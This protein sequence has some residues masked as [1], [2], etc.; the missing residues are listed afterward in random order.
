MKIALTTT[1]ALLAGPALAQTDPGEGIGGIG[2]AA[3][4]DIAGVENL[5]LLAQ[6][7]DWGLG[8]LAGRQDGGQDAMGGAT[9][10]TSDPADVAVAIATYCRQYPYALVLDA[11]RGYGLEVFPDGPAPDPA[12]G[13]DLP[14]LR[15]PARPVTWPPEA[16]AIAWL[17]EGNPSPAGSARGLAQDTAA[18]RLSTQNRPAGVVP[19]LRPMPRPDP[20]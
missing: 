5:P 1:L 4:E 3:C 8:Y 7:T 16:P 18:D 6:A 17:G 12:L 9:L 20:S 10:S 19:G 14:D 15:P 2:T 11:V 13:P